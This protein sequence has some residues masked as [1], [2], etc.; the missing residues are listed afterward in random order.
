[1]RL[2]ECNDCCLPFLQSSPLPTCRHWAG[3]FHTCWT[4]QLPTRVGPHFS[5]KWFNMS[6][7]VVS[8]RGRWLIASNVFSMSPEWRE[9]TGKTQRNRCRPSGCDR[10]WWGKEEFQGLAA[11]QGERYAKYTSM[12]TGGEIC[13]TEDWVWLESGGNEIPSIEIKLIPFQLV[14]T[15]K[16]K[17]NRLWGVFNPIN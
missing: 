15:T 2:G 8:F 13:W 12:G 7:Q 9:T 4:F 16:K 17:K 11:T 1:M 14:N 10:M 5:L 6:K 3:K